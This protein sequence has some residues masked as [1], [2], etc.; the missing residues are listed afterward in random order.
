M[1]LLQQQVNTTSLKGS[2]GVMR[3]EAD[4]QPTPEQLLQVQ[5]REWL[6]GCLCLCVNYRVLLK[7]AKCS[8][9]VCVGRCMSWP[10]T[11][12]STGITMWSQRPWSSCSRCS[13]LPRQSFC[14]CS[15]PPAAFHT[16]LCFARTPRAA[17]APEAS[18]S[19]LVNTSI[20][21]DC[22]HKACYPYYIV[23]WHWQCIC[24]R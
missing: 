13:G 11:T 4:V 3:K 24:L 15:S 6:C 18:S 14:T 8:M 20:S 21:R 12:R 7:N 19:S 5:R 16:A 2:F 17:H 1:P 22:V 23:T 10:Y 9:C